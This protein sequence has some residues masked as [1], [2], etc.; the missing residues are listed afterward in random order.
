MRRRFILW[1]KSINEWLYS[2]GYHPQ[3][4]VSNTQFSAVLAPCG[5]ITDLTTSFFQVAL[6]PHV[7]HLF[8]FQDATGNVFQLTALPMGLCISPEMM[9]HVTATLAGHPDFG[10]TPITNAGV[11]VFIDNIQVS[12]PL[13]AVTAAMEQIK[14]NAAS[15]SITLN[16]EE[17]DI[18][19]EY[20]FAG[21]HYHHRSHTV[22]LG[23]KTHRKL[24]TDSI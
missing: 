16:A 12:G 3:V 5:G 10:G 7:R 14:Q 20:T 1:P 4:D 15:L 17:T 2:T 21:V 23:D 9:Q 22:K 6:P 24:L 18:S 11:N 8:C 19:A 13:D